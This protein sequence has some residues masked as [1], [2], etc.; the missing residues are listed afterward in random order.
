M[1]AVDLDTG[2]HIFPIL[3]SVCEKGS[4]EVGKEGEDSRLVA[5]SRGRRQLYVH[6]TS[7]VEPMISVHTFYDL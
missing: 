2:K 1:V 5:Q 7:F 4:G 6:K 3:W